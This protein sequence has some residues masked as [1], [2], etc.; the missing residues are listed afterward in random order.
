MTPADQVMPH[1]RSPF[2]RPFALPLAL[3]LAVA[4]ALSELACHS[5]QVS[6]LHT[7]DVPVLARASQ[8]PDL[9]KEFPESSPLQLAVLWTKPEE[10]GLGLLHSLRQMGI[11][12]FWTRRL[13]QALKHSRLLLYPSVDAKTFTPEQA[14]QLGRYVRDGGTIFAQNVFAGAVKSLFGFREFSPSRGR[15]WV[16]FQTGDDSVFRYL[17]RPE[18]QKVRLGSE[19]ISEIFWTNGYSPDPS[20]KVL[21]RFEDGAAA[22]LTKTS[23]KGKIYLAGVGLDDVTVRNQSNRDFEAQRTYVNA[24]EPGTD[25]W[26]L[27]LRAWYEAYTQNWI[28]LATI[29]DGRRSVLLL[30]HDLDSEPSVSLTE[31]YMAMEHRLG[32]TSTLFMQ[33][34]YADDSIGPALLS[35]RNLEFLHKAKAEGFEL[36]SH[37]VSHAL[38]FNKFPKGTGQE[39]FGN[40]RPR[41]GWGSKNYS[42]GSVFGEVRVSKQLLDGEVP[43]QHTIFFRAGH[44]RVPPALPEALERCGYEFDS[45]FTAGDVLTNFPYSLPLELGMIE[46]TPIYEFPVTLEDEEAPGLSAHLESDLKVIEA[47]AGNG[48]INV[49]LVHPNDPGQKVPAEEALIRRL[50]A[51]VG[52]S[53]LASFARYWRARDHLRW[54]AQPT[55]DPLEWTLTI[56]GPELVSGLTFEFQRSIA[57]ADGIASLQVEPHR[58][59]LPALAA[60]QEVVLRIRYAA[61]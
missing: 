40:Y 22:L 31:D 56:R 57:K 7:A 61:N 18:E 12:F 33:M 48:A 13:D 41:I 25:V 37:S 29:P 46:D 51:G 14:E 36:G 17:D 42:D 47:N 53:D 32:S 8:R 49:L 21:A 34:K 44:L 27:M 58:L 28:R 23:G 50:P 55:R 15:H 6:S 26:M 1:H 30:S 20:A 59:I 16:S 45:S 19:K 43:S 9:E 4:G 5:S 11:P 10:T 52:A 35:A 38:T 54:M 3:V 60:G 24:F 2:S 39:S